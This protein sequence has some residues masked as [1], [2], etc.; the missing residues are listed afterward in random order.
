MSRWLL[1]LFLAA[2]GLPGVQAHDALGA[3]DACL[4]QLDRG[5]D[6]GYQ[7]IVARCP[8]LAPSLTQSQWAAWLPRDWNKPDNLLSP[9]GLTELRTLLTREPSFAPGTRA[10]HVERVAAVLATIT[11]ADRAR[12]GWWFRLKQWL[13]EVLTPRPQGAN[14]GWLRRVIGDLGLSQTVLEGIVWGAL[15]LV[16]ALAAAVV[17]NELRIAG[18]LKR[19]KPA[20]ARARAAADPPAAVTLQ[21][22]EHASPYQQPKLLLELIAARLGEQDR[23]P[24][25]RSLTVHELTR[26]ARLPQESDRERLRELAA[27]CERVRFSDRELAPQALAAALAC[28]RELLAALATPVVHPQGA[29]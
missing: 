13:R 25:A 14:Q 9:D 16:I 8:D 2:A 15:L 4:R 17:V 5:L 19:W 27:A 22:L 29:R 20:P 3:I 1:A 7:R 24:P 12:G 18:L 21:D 10:P 11:Q 28:G 26:A 23:L 6:V